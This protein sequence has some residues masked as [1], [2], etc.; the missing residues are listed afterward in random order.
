MTLMAVSFP[1]LPG[2]TGDWLAWHRE[3]NGSRREE[4]VEARRRI[5]VRERTFLQRTPHGD[6]VLVTFEGDDPAWSFA[7]LARGTDPF[8]LWVIGKV[9]ELHGVDLTQPGAPLPDL[10]SDSGE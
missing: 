4:F 9:R 10:V 1:I 3:L 7:E 5:R 2:K 8:T 6:V